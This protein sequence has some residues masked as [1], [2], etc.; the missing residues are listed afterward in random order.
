LAEESRYITAFSTPD[1]GLHRFTRLIMGASPSG[2][3]FH[4]IIHDLIRE[5][6][7][8]ANI[9]DNIW[10]W[11]PDKKIDLQQLDQLLSKLAVSGITLKLPKFSFAIPQINVFGHIVSADDIQ[12]DEKKNQSHHR[13]ASPYQC[14]RSPVISWPHQLLF[15]AHPR[16]QHTQISPTAITESQNLI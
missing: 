8:T 5:I 2:E 12:P 1:D 4:E 10:I 11:S 7:G 13:C 15:E 14:F 9:S 16:L 3:H 6:S